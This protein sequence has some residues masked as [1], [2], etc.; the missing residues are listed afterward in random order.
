MFGKTRLGK[1]NVVKII[2]Q[3]IIE[4][5]REDNSVG[6]LIFD[7]NGEYANDNPQD[8]SRSLRSAY[9]NRCEVYALTPKPGTPS[10][11]LKLNFYEQPDSCMQILRS[12]LEPMYRGTQYVSSFYSV[13]LPNIDDIGQMRPGS[14]R[15]RPV[16]KV[17]MYWAIL[18][19]AG[20]AADEA[21]LRRLGLTGG[22][23][24]APSNFNPHFNQ[25]LIQA[26]YGRNNQFAPPQNLDELRAHLE[27]VETFRHQNPNDQALSSRSGSLFDADDVALLGFLNPVTG[28]GP[29]ILRPHMVYHDPQAGNFVQNI[30]QSLDSG[31]TVILDLGNATDEIRR[32]FSDLLS[33]AVFSNQE[34]KFTSNSLND[35]YIQ[36][37]FEEAHNL[38]PKDNKDFTGIYAR[39]AKEGAKFHIGIVY[40]TQSPST[41]N[42][43][44]LAQTE[45]FFVAHMSSQSEAEALAKLQIQYDGL[46]QDILKTRTPG[47]MRMMTFSHRFVIPVQINRFE[48]TASDN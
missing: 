21:R 33:R 46:Q 10:Q 23:R 47:Y 16:R 26:V 37:Y 40:S 9:P 15:T 6:Q 48:A 34:R 7:I 24:H 20:F 44:L 43:E 14:Q 4:T 18:N 28:G 38:F 25:Q 8:G 42:K 11:P 1:S 32:Y 29:R 2:S 5:T 17:Q 31:M 27:Q 12:L 3:S 45:N 39:F 19:K 13:Q 41:I 35:Q 30:L 22:S 36:L